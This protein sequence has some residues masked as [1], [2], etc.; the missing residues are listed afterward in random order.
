MITGEWNRN[1]LLQT[2]VVLY[3]IYVAGLWVTNA[4]YGPRPAVVPGGRPPAT[5][6]WG[7]IWRTALGTAPRR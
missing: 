4:V 7:E 5:D 2:I 6:P 3:S 1:R